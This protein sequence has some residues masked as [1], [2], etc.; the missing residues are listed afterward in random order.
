MALVEYWAAIDAEDE[1]DPWH[2]EPDEP[3]E[4]EFFSW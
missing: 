2:G 3:G 4:V 1:A